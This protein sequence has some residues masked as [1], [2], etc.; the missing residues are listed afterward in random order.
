MKTTVESLKDYYVKKGGKLSDVAGLS[1]I[2]EMID[3]IATLPMGGKDGESAY[4]IAV[5]H[6]FAG[7]EEEWLESLQG[8]DGFSPTITV[9]SATE[10]TYI[11]TVN[12]ESGSYDTPNL[13]GSGGGSGNIDGL[14]PIYNYE[15]ITPTIYENKLVRVGTGVIMNSS[16][17]DLCEI[18]VVEGEIYTIV[19][20]VNSYAALCVVKDANDNVLYS[21]PTQTRDLV[22]TEGIRVIIPEGGVKLFSCKSHMSTYKHAIHKA[23]DS[24]Q[25]TIT[26]KFDVLYNK[27][28]YALGDS[29]TWGYFNYYT[30]SEG[31]KG[32]YSD[33]FDDILGCFKTYPWCI[34]QRCGIKAN[35][36]LSIGGIDFTNTADANQ[37]FSSD[38]SPRNYTMIPNDCDYITLQFGLNEVNLTVEQIG[39]K[40]DT[41]N[42]TLWGAY[43]VVL[44]S[45]L[46]ANPKVKIGIIISDAWMTQTYHDALIE[47]AKY[48]GIPYLDLKDGEQ[49]PMMINGEL[50]EHSSVAEQLRNGVFKMSTDDHPTLIAHE[51]RSTVIENF[52]RSL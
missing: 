31:H 11:L 9:K 12:N 43:N 36:T 45:I 28:W 38:A 22:L 46:T 3:A 35:L 4:E 17:Y 50:R 14:E 49:V 44:E 15:L 1:T 26:N 51:Y 37:P 39:T 33:A 18:S 24:G 13:K 8:E 21:Y 16:L 23:L 48:W 52:L 41:T 29:F 10:D 42:E 32:Q 25:R 30:D 27:K 34:Q 2:P 40:T 47:I 5:D 19:G 20:T 7:T 6:G